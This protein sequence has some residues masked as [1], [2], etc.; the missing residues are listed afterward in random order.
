M[1]TV[2]VTGVNRGLGLE[3]IRQYSDAGWEVIGTC[4]DLGQ[5]MEASALADSHNNVELYPLEVTSVESV[6]ALVD[7]LAGRAIDVLL[8]NAGVMSPASKVMGALEQQDFLHCLNVN[9]VMP[10]LMMQAFRDH[11]KRSDLKL[12]VGMSSTLGSI[13]GNSEGGLYSY[14]ASK[15]ALNAVV[16]SASHDLRDDGITVIALHP[17]WVKTDMGGPDAS[18]TVGESITG[19]RNVIATATPADSGRF[20]SYDGESLPW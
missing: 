19:M 15:A 3:F 16:K 14:R 13:E 12:M 6:N 9:T 17:G 5:A 1:P 8:L 7:S 20:V 10:A 4:R 2:L 18:I 11:V